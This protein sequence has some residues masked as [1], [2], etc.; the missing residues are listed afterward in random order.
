M[1]KRY[2][3]LV[4]LNEIMT[5]PAVYVDIELGIYPP[6]KSPTHTPSKKDI[7]CFVV[8]IVSSVV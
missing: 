7:I 8:T 2:C 1:F 4:L 3:W 6:S 5:K